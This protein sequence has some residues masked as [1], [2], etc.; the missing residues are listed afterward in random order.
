[1]KHHVRNTCLLHFR[2][3]Y[4]VLL[5]LPPNPIVESASNVQVKWK[6]AIND[7]QDS[8][9][10][11]LWS[12][13]YCFLSFLVPLL[14][15]F[16][17]I[18]LCEYNSFDI[19]V[20]VPEYTLNVQNRAH[21]NHGLYMCM[22]VTVW[23]LKLFPH[24]LGAGG[25]RWAVLQCLQGRSRKTMRTGNARLKKFLSFKFRMNGFD[26]TW[27][28]GHAWVTFCMLCFMRQYS[29]SRLLRCSRRKGIKTS[30]YSVPLI[31][32]REIIS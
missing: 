1:M 3:I 32:L 14:P 12:N 25:K 13:T 22:V 15:S 21:R 18:V 27:S 31:T 7:Q 5:N 30:F 17:V 10:N 28:A 9:I 11:R 8:L 29:L 20:P 26:Q 16:L 4:Q 19:S 24:D 2:V 23:K 6:I